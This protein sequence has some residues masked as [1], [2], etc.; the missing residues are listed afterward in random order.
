MIREESSGTVGYAV[1]GLGWIAQAAVIPAFR[2]ASRNSRL[3]ALVSGEPE[4]LE[5]VGDRHGV[6]ERY[7]YDEYDRCLESDAVDA[8]YIAL[9]NHLHR[10][11][12]VRAARAGV[13]VL[14][15]KPMALEPSDCRAMI[16][17]ADEA[18]VRL[19]IAYRLHF[20]EANLEAARLVAGGE[21]GEPRYVTAVFNTRVEEPDN[22]RLSADAGGGTLYDIGVYCINATRYL[23]RAEPE[24][25]W[26]AAASRDDPRFE[27]VPEMTTA[28]L[29]FPGDRLATFTC[30]FG[31]ADTNAF[32][33]EGSEGELLVEPAFELGT[34]YRHRLTVDGER[35]SS[36]FPERDQFGPE[37][38]HFSDCVQQGE[39]PGPSGREGLADV[40]II[41]ALRRSIDTGRSVSLDPYDPGSRPTTAREIHCPPVETPDLAGAS[42]P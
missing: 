7:T 34:E 32:R 27:E 11:Y 40:R 8:V 35:R 36:V 6:D 17:A 31:A 29:S 3:A 13:H 23:F 39:T 42:A 22:I 26:A 24:K 12:A 28:T 16:E 25:V 38:L 20:E 9:P 21:I 30:S 10:D 14:C 2:N 4:K 41:D 1:V 15:E 5:E 37:L 18:D 19:M 33:V